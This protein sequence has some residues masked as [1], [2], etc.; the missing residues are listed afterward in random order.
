M[1]TVGLFVNTAKPHALQVATEACDWL[2]KHGAKPLVPDAEAALLGNPDTVAQGSGLVEPGLLCDISRY[3]VGC[4]RRELAAH[5]DLL[6]VL[7]GDGTLLDAAHTPDIEKVPILA[8]NLGSL[9]FLTDVPRDQLYAA[10]TNVFNGDYKIDRRMM[11]EVSVDNYEHEF[12]NSFALND[13]VIRHYT[14]LIELEA[15]IDGEPFVTYNA[16]GLI[17]ATSSGSTAY[18]LACGGPI[19]EPHLNA[20]LLTPISPHSLTMR[21]FIAHGDS[22][23]TVVMQSDYSS[24]SLL[25]DGARETH[26]VAPNSLIRVRKADKTIQLIRSHHQSNYEVLQTKLMLGEGTKRK[27]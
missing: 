20:I 13:V 6:L 9:G 15:Y 24:V 5:C 18:S 22:E 19:V 1:K 4:D 25:V 12:S 23:I 2:Q 27:T 21:P 14:Q 16:D 17:I 8:V 3:S 7:G 10:L 26:T 11:L